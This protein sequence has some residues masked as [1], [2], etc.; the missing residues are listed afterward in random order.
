MNVNPEQECDHK[1]KY[2]LSGSLYCAIRYCIECGKA[3]R[4]FI[5][6]EYND[7][8]V[9]E[10]EEIKEHMEVPPLAASFYDDLRPFVDDDDDIED[11]DD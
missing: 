2:R 3:W 4:T 7:V 1:G 8:P 6:P 9:A 11:D 10:W 5:K